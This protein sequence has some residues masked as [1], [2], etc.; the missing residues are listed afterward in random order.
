MPTVPAWNWK[1]CVYR[2]ISPRRGPVLVPLGGDGHYRAG[3]PAGLDE[4][5]PGFIEAYTL[6]AVNGF[7]N[8]TFVMIGIGMWLGTIMWFIVWFVIWPNQHK[9]LN[10]GGKFTDLLPA[11][12]GCGRRRRP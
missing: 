10:I 7:T 12:K 2:N 4:R 5:L 8:P 1:P 3:H 9:A 6:D 11:G